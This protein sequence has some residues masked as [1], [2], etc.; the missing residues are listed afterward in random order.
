M[1]AEL[2]STSRVQAT[3]SLGNCRARISRPSWCFDGGRVGDVVLLCL[4]DTQ[5]LQVSAWRPDDWDS[6]VCWGSTEGSMDSAK[7]PISQYSIC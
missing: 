1:M 5:N 6:P 7:L 3:C 4:E 2:T